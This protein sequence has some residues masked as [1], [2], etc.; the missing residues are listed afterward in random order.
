MLRAKAI[1]IVSLV[2]LVACGAS[3]DVVPK[4]DAD[5]IAPPP[6]PLPSDGVD[7]PCAGAGE[8]V[9]PSKPCCAG[10]VAAPVFKGSIIR[11]DDCVRVVPPRTVCLACGDGTCGVE[12]T[13]CNCSSD[14]PP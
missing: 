12:E 6:K 1:A 13:T 5:P 3:R 9:S 4:T 8:D 11:L 14:C 2:F 7:R 10:L